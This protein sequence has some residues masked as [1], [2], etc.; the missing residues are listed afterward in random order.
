MRKRRGKEGTVLPRERVI[1][2]LLFFYSEA[3]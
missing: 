3:P 1:K 2:K